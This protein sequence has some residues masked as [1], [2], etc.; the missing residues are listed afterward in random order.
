[1][2]YASTHETTNHCKTPKV[3]GG[4]PDGMLWQCSC[5]LVWRL[6]TYFYE[7]GGKGRDWVQ[8][9]RLKQA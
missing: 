9:G 5:G 7:M 6:T 8:A 2:G 3:K 1:M 4:Y